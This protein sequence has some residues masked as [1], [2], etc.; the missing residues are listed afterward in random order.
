SPKE[1]ADPAAYFMKHGS[2]DKCEAPT[3]TA[4]GGRISM[5]STC[6]TGEFGPTEMV[7]T[8]TYAREEMHLS[9]TTSGTRDGVPF[10]IESTYDNRLIGKCS[11]SR[12]SFPVPV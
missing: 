4:A 5:R 9:V 2:G 12:Q 7:V 8:G 3:G 6:S 1:A 11:T 10:E